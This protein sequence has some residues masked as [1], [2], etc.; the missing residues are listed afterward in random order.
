LP[1][2]AHILAM[3]QEGRL[4][5]DEEIEIPKRDVWPGISVVAERWPN[6]RRFRLGQLLEWMVAQSDNTVV[7]TLYRIGGGGRTITARLRQW[8][9]EDIRLDRSERQ[10]GRDAEASINRFLRDPRDT[11]TPDGAVELF[12]KLFAGQL[13]SAP[14]TA[15]LIEILKATT[16]RPGRL[17]GLL[18]AGTV[19]AHRSGTAPT[20][21]SLSGGTNDAGVIFL[22]TGAQLAVAVFLKG[23]TRDLAAREHVIAQIAKA[24]FDLAGTLA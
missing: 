10:C 6:P 16:S 4:S 17:K 23:S 3:V 24:A 14:L 5:L 22:P 8:K 19:V 12:R 11:A 9:L 20:V 7:E 18:P 2:A 15:H 21:G 13:L 1:I